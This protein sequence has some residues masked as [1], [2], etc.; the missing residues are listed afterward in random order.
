MH[1]LIGNVSQGSELLLES[2]ENYENKKQLFS[3]KNLN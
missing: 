3:I 1:I 2:L